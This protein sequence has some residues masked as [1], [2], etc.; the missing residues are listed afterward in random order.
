MKLIRTGFLKKI[1]NIP[2]NLEPYFDFVICVFFIFEKNLKFAK[3]K[4]FKHAKLLTRKKGVRISVVHGGDAFSVQVIVKQL[5]HTY[6]EFSPPQDPLTA[7][8]SILKIISTLP[9]PPLNALG[10]LPQGGQAPKS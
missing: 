5:S 10:H 1:L 7:D 9:N 6:T 4:N 2:K 3:L 8:L